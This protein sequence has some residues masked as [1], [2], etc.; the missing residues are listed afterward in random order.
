MTTFDILV[1]S[2]FVLYLGYRLLKAAG[3]IE[4][5]FVSRLEY[6]KLETEKQKLE[7]EVRLQNS[8][9]SHIKTL[10]IIQ[11][12]RI[13]SLLADK[14]GFSFNEEMLKRLIFLCAPDKHNDSKMATDITKQLLSMRDKKK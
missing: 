12:R 9:I 6:I 5:F 4:A 3:F 10:C 1:L 11:E 13:N 8:T 7:E 2:I 14:Q